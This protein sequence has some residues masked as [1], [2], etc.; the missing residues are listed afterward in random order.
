MGPNGSGKSTLS[1]V[2]AGHPD[3]RVTGGQVRFEVNFRHQDLLSLAAEERAREGLFLAFQY[4]TEVPGVSNPE[5]LRASFNAVV[6]H[7]GGEEMGSHGF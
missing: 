5:F 1:K 3:Y 6:A 4:P 2:I 7:Q